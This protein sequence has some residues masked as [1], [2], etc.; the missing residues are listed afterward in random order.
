MLSK[1]QWSFSALKFYALN[2]LIFKSIWRW[3][4]STI[5]VSIFDANNC[6]SLFLQVL[7]LYRPSYK[8]QIC[9]PSVI[10]S[11]ILDTWGQRGKAYNLTKKTPLVCS[12]QYL[13]IACSY[14]VRNTITY[15]VSED[16]HLLINIS[17][18]LPW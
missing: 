17:F 10:L 9:L 4:W 15:I 8:V 1:V 13:W 12:T 7:I 3:N 14:S 16:L 18:R 6:M 5:E 2:S 11:F